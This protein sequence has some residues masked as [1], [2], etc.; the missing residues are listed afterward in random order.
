MAHIQKTI[1]RESSTLMS[2]PLGYCFPFPNA[3]QRIHEH[4]HRLSNVCPAMEGRVAIMITETERRNPTPS[5]WGSMKE[6]AGLT[7]DAMVRVYRCIVFL[8]PEGFMLFPLWSPKHYRVVSCGAMCFGLRCIRDAEMTRVIRTPGWSR[9]HPSLD[10]CIS[11]LTSWV[12]Y[13]SWFGGGI[14]S[15]V[16]L[17]L[18]PTL[19]RRTSVYQ[20]T[21]RYFKAVSK[22]LSCT[23]A[24]AFT[25]CLNEN[26]GTR[27]ILEH[28]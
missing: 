2:F 23:S 24:W 12:S 4:K 22:H 16:T 3:V 28:V 13:N 26:I 18:L 20:N 17:L 8:F 15:T 11:R 14:R 27:L 6:G 9:E 5:W 7:R 10:T 25:N 21:V 1:G 19:K